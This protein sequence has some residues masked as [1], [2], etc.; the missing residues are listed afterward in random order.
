MQTLGHLTVSVGFLALTLYLKERHGLNSG[1]FL[2]VNGEV[3]NYGTIIVKDGGEL[4]ISTSATLLNFGT[5][6][7]SG[8]IND[9]GERNPS[10]LTFDP[11]GTI[12]L[13][14]ITWRLLNPQVGINNLGK[15]INT[16]DIDNIFNGVIWNNNEPTGRIFGGDSSGGVSCG[17]DTE[18]LDNVCVVTQALRDEITDLEAALAAALFDLADA[19]LAIVG[20]EVEVEELSQPGA[21]VANQGEGQGVPTQGKNN[22]P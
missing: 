14:G 11:D 20:L 19:L 10:G 22:K 1:A 13:D 2:I 4:E 9:S 3:T 8:R 18:L 5:I 7:N 15:I 16:G 6:L 17:A 21:P 12:F